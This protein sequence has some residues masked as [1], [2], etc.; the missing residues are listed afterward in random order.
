MNAA[1]RL[2]IDQGVA[3]TTIE[4]ITVGA[5]VAKGSFYIHFS[6][7]E[8]V[9]ESLR[10]RFVGKVRNA[11]TAEVEQRAGGDWGGRLATWATACAKGYAASVQLHQIVFH[12]VPPPTRDGLTD[13]VLID[14]LAQL[15]ADGSAKG[16]WT[17]ADVRFTALFLFNALHGV[18][19]DAVQNDRMDELDRRMVDHCL[20][21]VGWSSDNSRAS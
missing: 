1:E 8:D 2:F 9:V 10:Q 13:N 12:D 16:A 15:L 5:G 20:R 17:I 19:L 14:D 7:K 4:Q 18:I 6:S 3:S 11:I 21:L